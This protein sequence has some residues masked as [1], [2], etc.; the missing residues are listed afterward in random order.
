MYSKGDIVFV[1]FPYSDLSSAKKRPVVILGERDEDIVVCAI[2]SSPMSDGLPINTLQ[3]GV[4]AFESKIKYWQF[5]TFT[6]SLVVRKVGK[7]NMDDHR[8]LINK[9]HEFIAI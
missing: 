4:L 1:S 3:E 2:T 8:I 6:K 5:F 7:I 9:I